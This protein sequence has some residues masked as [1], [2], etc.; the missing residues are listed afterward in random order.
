MVLDL[1]PIYLLDVLG[2]SSKFFSATPW[3]FKKSTFSFKTRSRWKFFDV[4]QAR[5]TTRI[6]ALTE[7]NNRSTAAELVYFFGNYKET[8]PA[9]LLL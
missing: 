8:I 9:L 2:M 7:N 6:M 5:F 1:Q 4:L 3:H